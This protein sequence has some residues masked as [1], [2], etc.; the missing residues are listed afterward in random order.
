MFEPSPGPRL[1]HVPL[2]ADFPRALVRG[3]D[4]RLAG[5]PPEARARVELIVNSARM[6]RRVTEVLQAGPP[7]LLPR[8]RVVTDM[9]DPL[10]MSA[11]PI[12]V[13]PLRRRL[14][15]AQAVARLLDAV[16]EL[17]PRASL[18]DLADGLAA[19]VEE[20]HTEGVSPEALRT[21]D[22]SDQSGHWQRALKFL[23]ILQPYFE[24]VDAPDQA[25][26]QRWAVEARIARWQAAPPPHPVIVAGSTGSRGTTRLLME[27][28]ARLPQGAVVLP[29][30]DTDMPADVWNGLSDAMTGEDHPQFRFA[31]LMRALDLT[32]EAVAPWSD[33]PAPSPARNRVWSLALRPAPVTD[34]WLAEGPGLPDL[35]GAMDGVT[36]LEAPGPRDEAQAIALRLRQAAEAG[37]TAALITPDRMLTRQVT[38]ALDRWGIRPDDSAGIPP[39]LTAPGRFLRHV[40]ALDTQPLT[41]EALIELLKHPLCHAG[42]GRN[43]HLRRTRDLE[44]HI[45]KEGLPYPTP[46]ALLHWAESQAAPEW[47]AWLV[48]GLCAPPPAGDLPLTDWADRHIARAEALCAGSQSEDATQLWAREPGQEVRRQVDELRAEA[49]HGGALSARDYA[50]MFGALLARGEVRDSETRHPHILIWGTI[51]TRV[52]GADLLIL[53]GLNEGSWPEAPAADPWLNRRMRHDAG[54]L[55]PERRIGL[56]AHDFQIAAAAPEVWLTRALRSQDAESVPSRWINRLTNLLTGLPGRHGPEA[57]AAMRARGAEWVAMARIAETPVPIPP[58]PRPAPCPPVPAR[59]RRLSVTEIKTLI[60]DPYAIYAKHVLGLRPLQ[61]LQRAPDALIRGIVLHELFEEYVKATLDDPDR[62]T[63]EALTE[64]SRQALWS[65]IPWPAMRPVWQARVERVAPWFARS[66]RARQALARPVLFEKSGAAALE[67]VDFTL[68]GKADRIDMDAHGYAHVYDYKTG[69]PPSKDEQKHFDKQLLLEA[70]MIE[71]GGFSDI[72]PRGVASAVYIGLGPD[73]KEQAAPLDEVSAAQIWAEFTKLMAAYA[74]PARGYPSRNATFKED[75]VADYDQLAR[76]GEWD[77][78]MPPEKVVL[79]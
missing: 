75:D 77:G 48:A 63:A 21:L 16:P 34:R 30:F 3:L 8:L 10:D 43:G 55:L 73:P 25:A 65:D 42:A 13:S 66:E 26:L 74:D 67:G 61:P 14:E 12:P 31:T 38:A 33:L 2:G 45:R 7:G 39:Q 15:L 52:M 5:Q 35:V 28:V 69:N 9:A 17:A 41:A 29:G 23:T 24:A 32:P 78:S 58:A 19:L 6:R 53:G 47:G 54:L 64:M 20:L 57:L 4:A 51:E 37:Q 50:D 22:V 62:L 40:A 59:P 76:F 56:S 49:M 36:L 46:E 72:S 11:M 27:A 70:A 44:L 18:Y 68:R 71:R 79:E 1:F 60:R